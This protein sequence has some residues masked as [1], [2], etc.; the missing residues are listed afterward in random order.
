[1][2][3][4]SFRWRFAIIAIVI[5]LVSIPTSLVLFR[6]PNLPAGAV[7]PAAA[8]VLLVGMKVFEG[9]ALGTGIAFLIFGYPLLKRAGQSRMLTLLAYLAIGWYLVNWWPHDNL[10]IVT[11]TSNVWALL[12]IEYAFH[13]TMMAAA[14]VLAVFFYRGIRQP[15]PAAAA[16]EES[17]V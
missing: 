3:K 5:G 9:L 2:S 14:G 13:C 17:R 12:A 4:L 16:A 11:G 6:P 8:I 15:S 7:V 1:M 10:H